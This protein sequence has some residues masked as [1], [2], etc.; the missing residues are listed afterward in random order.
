MNR[1]Y[2]SFRYD[3]DGLPR[4]VRW[5]MGGAVAG[6]LL[7]WFFP[8]LALGR[9][10]FSPHG[11]VQQGR[12]WQLVTYPFLSYRF[13]TVFFTCL[14]LVFF[15]SAVERHWGEGPLLRYLALCY[16][17]SA[18]GVLMLAPG[19]PLTIGGA[20]WVGYWLVIAFAMLYPDST[21]Y[22]LLFPV[23]S[24]YL[25]AF[26]VLSVYFAEDPLLGG[27]RARFAPLFGMLC[28]W[29]YIRFSGDAW[30]RLKGW[31]RSLTRRDEDEYA[32]PSRRAS[33]R[34][35][36]PSR[37]ASPP[38]QDGMEEVDRILDKILAS[39]LESLTEDEKLI[40][41]RYSDKQRKHS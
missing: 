33:P 30:I 13:T 34:R 23:R 27:S 10:A 14:Y 36:A 19:Q 20:I 22:F 5:L 35:S 7:V 8:D 26:A 39:G 4:L 37:P 2:T 24:I 1:A 3:Y 11:F 21:V 38:A 29:L 16:A 41:K 25:V 17:A 9:L 31:M 15:G 28:G 6:F 40:M 32:P 12:L 18:L